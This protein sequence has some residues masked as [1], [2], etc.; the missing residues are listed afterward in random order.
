MWREEETEQGTSEEGRQV[1][2]LVQGAGG[3]RKALVWIAGTQENERLEPGRSS[4]EILEL[5]R[6]CEVLDRVWHPMFQHGLGPNYVP[7]LV[8]LWDLAREVTQRQTHNTTCDKCLEPGNL[9]SPAARGQIPAVPG[10]RRPYRK[11]QI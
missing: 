7:G 9:L 3:T 10:P 8:T 11:P 6:H 1:T 5:G 2:G 4:Q